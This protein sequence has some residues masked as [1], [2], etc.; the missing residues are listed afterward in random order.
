MSQEAEPKGFFAQFKNEEEFA[1]F[2]DIIKDIVKEAIREIEEPPAR[3]VLADRVAK[4]A[5]LKDDRLKMP[6]HIRKHPEIYV[7]GQGG[8]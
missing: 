7:K 5:M 3:D 2:V 6:E 4:R 1:A 8:E